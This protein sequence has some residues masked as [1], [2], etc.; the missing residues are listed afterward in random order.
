MKKIWDEIVL[1]YQSVKKFVVQALQVFKDAKGKVSWK[2]VSGSAAFVVGIR[3]L[4]IGDH[5]GAIV[6]LAYAAVIG[7]VAAI[8][9]S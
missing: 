1:G 4:V 8:T 6:C 9:K 3:Q 7:I 5:F 2:R